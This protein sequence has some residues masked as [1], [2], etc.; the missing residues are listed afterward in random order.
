MRIA[1]G[2]EY[3]GS[4]YVGWQKQNNGVSVQEH[5]ETA[6]AKVANHPIEVICA[7]R[8]DRGVHAFGQVIHADAQVERTTRGWV[9]GTN[10]HL[11]KDIS[12][13]WAQAVD[14]DFHARFSAQARH[15]R[16]IISNRLSRPALHTK[17]VAWEYRPLNIEPMQQAAKFLIGKHDFT[18]YRTV[19]CQAR[20]PVRTIIYLNVS[21]Q[22]DRIYLDISADGF[23]HHMVRNIAGVLLDIGSGNK[24]PEWAKQVLD[25]QDRRQASVT[26]PAGGLYFY[27]V[28]YPEPYQFPQPVLMY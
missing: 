25:S 8:T 19:A 14:D 21:Q 20:S 11:P 9:L 10:T 1:F 15:Y 5:V 18:A 26:A 16:Y 28:D 3:D 7:G 24:P 27:K 17:K 6:I 13:L 22:H 4:S 12:I 2:V 23:L